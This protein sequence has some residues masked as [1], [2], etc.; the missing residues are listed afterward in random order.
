MN[1]RYAALSFLVLVWA[2][3]WVPAAAA[4]VSCPGRMLSCNGRCTDGS[5]DPNNCGTCGTKCTGSQTCQNGHCACPNGKT[6]CGSSCVDSQR[7]MLNCGACN[8][9]CPTGGFANCTNGKCSCGQG[10]TLCNGKCV[11]LNSGDPK[12]CGAC[13]KVCSDGQV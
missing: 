12:N 7:D 5:M 1:F 8:N 9:A 13:G 11:L 2:I 3:L 6:A 10:G 4:Q